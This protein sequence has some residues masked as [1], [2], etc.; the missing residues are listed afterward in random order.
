MI[1]LTFEHRI[2]KGYVEF[3]GKGGHVLYLD[4]HVAHGIVDMAEEQLTDLNYLLDSAD[5]A[6]N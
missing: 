2:S 4:G 5:T 3:H 1:E 6:G